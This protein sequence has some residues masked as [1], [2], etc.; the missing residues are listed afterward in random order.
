MNLERSSYNKLVKNVRQLIDAGQMKVDEF[1]RRRNVET[2]W[3]V[4]R[5]IHRYMDSAPLPHGTKK[6]FYENMTEDVGI[7]QSTLKRA[8]Q[9]YEAHPKGANWHLL[10]WGKIKILLTVK[11]SN[12]REELARDTG[13]KRW[14]VKELQ[15]QIKKQAENR[16]QPRSIKT[17]GVD[18]SGKLTLTR[19]R[20]GIYRIITDLYHGNGQG[21]L[22]D[23]GFQMRY[24]GPM[25]SKDWVEGDFVE[26]DRNAKG[27]DLKKVKAERS[28]LFTFAVYLDHVVDGDTVVVAVETH[29]N[30]LLRQSLRLRGINTPERSTPEG[31]KAMK[32]VEGRLRP[33]MVIV[34]RTYKVDKYYRYV[35]DILYLPKEKDPYVIAAKGKFLNQEL[36]DKGLADLL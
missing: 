17:S 7:D 33:R 16:V 28:D 14:N 32:F 6:M 13:R 11:D 25:I 9:F 2:Y 18:S 15:D 30:M 20:P 29:L 35:S 34:A 24:Q 8:V 23:C 27:R 3:R 26:W 21:V 36:L 22:L 19:G 1:V 12:K 4:G 10:P 31:I 5:F